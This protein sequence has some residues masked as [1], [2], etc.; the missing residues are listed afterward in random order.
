MINNKLPS[1]KLRGTD[2]V[3]IDVVPTSACTAY[4]S[5]IILDSTDIIGTT[6]ESNLVKKQERTSKVH[7]MKIDL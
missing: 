6:F 5:P 4:A 1:D 2:G 3:S 7:I